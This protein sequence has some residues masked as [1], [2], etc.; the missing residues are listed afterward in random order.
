MLKH[1]YKGFLKEN[2]QAPKLKK[3]KKSADKSLS[4][5]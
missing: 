1:F 4:Q 5:P 3:N 2:L